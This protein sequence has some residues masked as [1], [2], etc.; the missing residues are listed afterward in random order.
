[1]NE[2]I[3]GEDTLYDEDIISENTPVTNLDAPPKQDEVLPYPEIKTSEGR[4]ICQVCGRDFKAITKAH[5]DLHKMSLDEYKQTYK[6]PTI[7]KIQRTIARVQ[8]TNTLKNVFKKQEDKLEEVPIEEVDIEDIIT[9]DLD[10]I[11]FDQDVEDLVPSNIPK[12]PTYKKTELCYHLEEMFDGHDSIE[13]YFI[14]EYSGS[15]SFPGSPQLLFSFVTDISIP[16]K[17]I[18]FFFPDTFW[19]NRDVANDPNKYKK[20]RRVGWKV[21]V[22]NGNDPSMNNI[23]QKLKESNLL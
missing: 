4:L 6:T 17:K 5:L 14:E 22:V 13:N 19:H 3:F 1:M 2:K 15:G 10:E 20:L 16:S 21:V 8:A 7:G 12:D 11:S 9:E 18:A 23:K